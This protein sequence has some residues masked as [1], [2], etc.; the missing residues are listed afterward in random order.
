MKVLCKKNYLELN[1][2]TAYTSG[3]YYDAVFNDSN[4]IF[5]VSDRMFNNKKL[6]YLF[7]INI[8][9][10]SESYF[11]TRDNDLYFDDY[12]YTLKELRK[13]KLDKINESIDFILVMIIQI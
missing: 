8:V 12:F 2:E 6:N 5:I 7:Y 11:F 1:D 3:I 4:H 9:D 13:I 10:P